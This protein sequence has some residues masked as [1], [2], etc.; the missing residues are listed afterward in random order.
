MWSCEVKKL[1][2]L[3]LPFSDI[4]LVDFDNE[5]CLNAAAFRC[6]GNEYNCCC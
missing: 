2:F 1:Q 3:A 4:V 5:I 6:I